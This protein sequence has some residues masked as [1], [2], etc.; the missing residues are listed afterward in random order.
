MAFL[1]LAECGD[2]DSQKTSQKKRFLRQ[3]F[4]NEKGLQICSVTEVRKSFKFC[5]AA[6]HPLSLPGL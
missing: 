6:F 4:A 3:I 5:E 1:I 2:S